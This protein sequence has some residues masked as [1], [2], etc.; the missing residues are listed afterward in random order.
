MNST[1]TIDCFPER[2]FLYKGY[3]AL[4][5]IDVIRATTTAVTAANA[6]MQIFPVASIKAGFKLAESIPQALLAGEMDGLKPD[7]FAITNSPVEILEMS[8]LYPQAILLSSSGTRLIL[9]AAGAN[10]VYIC[11]FRNLSAVADYLANRHKQIAILG[12]GSRGQFRRED[13]MGCA[14]LA[15]RLFEHGFV[16]ESDHIAAFVNHW[17]AFPPEE[18]AK[19]SSARYL[20]HSG[21]TRDLEFILSH[22]DDL[23]TVPSLVDNR[24][25]SLL[26]ASSLP[27]PLPEASLPASRGRP[28]AKD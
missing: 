26:S 2:A 24:I 27:C 25:V 22:I 21:Q 28:C 19:G 8:S 5:V 6:G 16:P 9:N 11:C 18:A 12:A 1:V 7:G 3:S 4:V 14:Y 15:S 23:E 20:L 10:P 17:A 13:K